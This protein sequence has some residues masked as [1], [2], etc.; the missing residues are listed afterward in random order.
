[1]GAVPRLNTLLRKSVV[2]VFL[3]SLLESRLE[4]RGKMDFWYFKG[5]NTHAG[6]AVEVRILI[7]LVSKVVLFANQLFLSAI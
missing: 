3:D 5:S 6:I 4:R 7:P 2:R 1:M